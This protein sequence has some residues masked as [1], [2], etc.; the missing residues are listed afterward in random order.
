MIS[1]LVKESYYDITEKLLG[2]MSNRSFHACPYKY[3]HKPLGAVEPI[4]ILLLR[5]V[6]GETKAKRKDKFVGC[7]IDI[8]L[9][10]Y[11]C[12]STGERQF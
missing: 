8:D 10:G 9:E 3:I 2:L 12:M 7:S 5:N 6:H 4:S 11:I 1:L